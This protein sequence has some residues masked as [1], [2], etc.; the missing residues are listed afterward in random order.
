[1]LGPQQ[2]A[3]K[4]AVLVYIVNETAPNALEARNIAVLAS[5]FEAF[6]TD[7]AQR[8]SG[9]ITEDLRLFQTAADRDVSEIKAGVLSLDGS[10]QPV[11][12]V[13]FS[14]R[15]AKRQAFEYFRAGLDQE[16]GE[17]QFPLVDDPH[18][19]AGS[20]PFATEANFRIALNLVAGMFDPN[21]HRFVLV[22]KS[23][24]SSQSLMRPKVLLDTSKLSEAEFQK[25]LARVPTSEGILDSSQAK[26]LESGARMGKENYEQAFELEAVGL[27]KE[28]FAA[29]MLDLSASRGLRFDV[30]FGFSCRSQLDTRLA[31]EL[32]SSAQHPIGV[33]YGSDDRGLDYDELSFAGVFAHLDAAGG[34]FVQALSRVLKGLEGRVPAAL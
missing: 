9:T 24:G 4:P 17:G 21:A 14:N 12:A 11:S 30:V 23:H 22:T 19:M 1:M 3:T 34:D 15:L 13:I 7:A 16:F 32:R 25:R 26:T 28:R 6:G 5:W 20:N 31:T 8:M 27:S 2:D 10:P 33:Y 18:F 29:A